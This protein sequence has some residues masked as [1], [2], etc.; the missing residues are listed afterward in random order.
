LESTT[1]EWLEIY[2]KISESVSDLVVIL[3]SSFEIIY[4]NQ[5]AS[6][7]FQIDDYSLTLAQ[8]FSDDTVK[9]LSDETGPSLFT[10]EKRYLKQLQ[11]KLK[12]GNIFEFDLTISTAKLVNEK[13]ILLVFSDSDISQKQVR[14]DQIQVRAGGEFLSQQNPEIGSLIKKIQSLLPFTL[15]G[16]KTLQV[17]IDN[18]DFPIWVKDKEERFIAINNVYADILGVENSI[19]QG[20]KQETFLPVHLIS[21]FKSIDNYILQTSNPIILDGIAKKVNFPNVSEQI[22]QI[23]ILD[24]RNQVSAIIGLINAKK[25]ENFVKQGDFDL[26]KRIIEGFPKPI[27][28][29]NFDGKVEHANKE[30]CNFLGEDWENLRSKSFNEFLPFLFSENVK[31]FLESDLQ[32]DEIFIDKNLNPVDISN[33]SEII[34]LLKISSTEE[35]KNFLILVD[36]PGEIKQESNELQNFI[37]NRGKMFDILIQKNP[38]PIFIYDKEN[39]KFLEVNDAAIKFYGFSR[40][41]FLQM[42]LTDL[43][44]P[45]DIQTLLNSFDDE[46]LE[47]KFSKPFRHRKKD[48]TTVVVEI[49]KTSFQFNDRE[50]HF[51]IVKDISSNVAIEKQNQMLKVIFNSTNSMVFTTDSSGFITYLNNPVIEKLGYTSNELLQS[52]FTSLVADEDRA[53]VNTSIFQS[54]VRDEVSLDTQLKKSDGEFLEAQ[55]TATP[56]MD[57]NREVES[58]TIIAKTSQASANQEKPREIVKEVIKEVVVEKQLETANKK[59]APDINFISGI[60][61]EILTPMNVII[62]F[63][64]EL[65]TGLENP[66]EEQK[67]AADIINQNR[68]KMMNTMNSISEYSEIILNKAILKPEDVSIT[69]VID[70]LDKNLN[71]ITGLNDIQFGYG[72]ISS[73]L[74]FKTDKQK[75]ENFIFYLIKVIARISKEKKVYFSAYSI[76]QDSLFVGLSDQ[77]GGATDYVADIFDSVFNKDKDPKDFGLPK[78][79]SHLAKVLL[80]LLNGKYYKSVVG[81]LRKEAGFVFPQEM[82]LRE[83]QPY[84]ESSSEE[85]PQQYDDWKTQSFTEVKSKPEQEIEEQQEE[86]Q[87]LEES[88]AE[89]FSEELASEVQEG[90]INET[91]TSSEELEEESEMMQGET[92]EPQQE[93]SE[94]EV[95]EELLQAQSSTPEAESKNSFEPPMQTIN[96]K[97]LS[98]LYIEDQVDSQ[99]LFK[100]QLKDLKDVKFAVSFEES[101]PLLLN[102]QF[103]FIVM[104]INLQGE[105]NGLDALKII[106]TMPALVNVPIIAVTAYVL[107]GDKEKFIAAGFDDFISKPI[108]REKMMESLEKIFLHKPR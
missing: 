18:Y 10:N 72:K 40:D 14:I 77:Y 37:K 96:L 44:A 106:K 105:Y 104:D 68:I 60:F 66:T 67:E 8:V 76:D 3:D 79:S 35:P 59:Y 87:D 29:L 16:L 2:A 65:V 94:A 84:T 11:L 57:F 12:S 82:I 19:A 71:E 91:E 107:P 15:V 45:E 98:C 73:S 90:D 55:I 21:I 61:H 81:S 39:L 58:F 30:F 88:L 32:S 17:L 50:A 41:E 1:K 95:E 43:Y 62:G 80:N 102:H 28:L 34:N 108:F 101:Q 100:V 5:K 9:K 38:E 33:A 6:S 4:S 54:N 24:Y 25:V 63:A 23:P 20:K 31:S 46:A 49:S 64:Q 69:E 27:A 74:I 92:L 78:L 85:T 56:I 26:N 75:F 99:I 22:I 70:V 86:M 7:L 53:L 83:A 93:I 13:I 52:S 48:G 42:D 51:N 103:D 97:D 89:D 47:G 36:K